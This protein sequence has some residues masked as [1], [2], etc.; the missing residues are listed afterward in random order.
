MKLKYTL[1]ALTV[2]AATTMASQAV[3][4]FNDDF[5][6][7]APGDP[8]DFSPTGN[9]VHNGGGVPGANQDRIFFSAPNYGG[10][11]LWIADNL[12]GTLGSGLNSRGITQGGDGLLGNSS[13][14]FS[15]AGVLETSVGTRNRSFTVDLLTGT[16]L[17]TAT[18]LIG[19]PQSFLA[20]GDDDPGDV[21]NIDNSY[22]DQRSEI[23]F[24]TGALGGSDELFIQIAFNDV[25]TS[26][27]AFVGIDEVSVDLVPEPSSTALL[28]LGGM[29]LLLRRR[30]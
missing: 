7:Y 22:D 25:S 3:L 20:R 8:S 21:G 26:G 24:N 19:G 1:A 5:E 23:A 30:K 12:N 14:L 13:Y 28:G 9:W 17:G 15:V 16:T 11:T 2:L 4:I 29:A 10:T 18:S 6:S 27:A